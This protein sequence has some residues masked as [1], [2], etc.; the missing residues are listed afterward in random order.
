[1]RREVTGLRSGLTW[2]SLWI[3]I[4][5]FSLFPGLLNS[6]MRLAQME[7][8]M[9]FILL[10]AVFILF[11]IVFNLS[12]RL[13]KMQKNFAKIVRETS[14]INYKIENEVEQVKKQF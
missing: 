12:S 9:F 4:G 8:R 5:F 14:L 10:L 6:A 3:G 1:M 7:N 11:A 2:I 13:E